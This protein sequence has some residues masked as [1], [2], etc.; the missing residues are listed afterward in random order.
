MTDALNLTR[1]GQILEVTLDRPKANAIDAATSRAMG[2]LFSEFCDDPSLRVAILTGAGE[3]FFSAGWD[4]NAAAQ[5]EAIESDYGPGGFAGLTELH[6]LNKPV[7]AAVNGLALG[8]GFELALACDVI[9]AAE[10]A[11]FSLPEVLVG[12]LADAGSFRLP[13][14]L[15]RAIAMEMLLTGRRMDAAEALS[16]GLVNAVAPP[17]G[18][19][20]KAREYAAM[21]LKAAPLAVAAVKEVTR[22]TEALNIRECYALL[23]SGTLP[24][25]MA[26]LNSEDAR[27]GPRA[28]TEKRA[29]IWKGS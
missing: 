25:F 2:A 8:G 21:I 17:A 19:M 29:P 6:D 11:Q 12:V 5:G 24:A 3:K 1:N 26:M 9:V 18:L 10:H 22:A 16:W 28:F 13:K 4:L 27:E 14:R 7:I 23:R 15:P 20:D